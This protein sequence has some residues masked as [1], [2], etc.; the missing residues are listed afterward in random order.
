MAEDLPTITAEVTD[1][2][3]SAT[4]LMDNLNAIVTDNSDEIEVFMQAGLPQLVRFVKEA[5][6]LVAN[7]QRLTAKI[8]RDPARFL[9]GIQS[10]EFR[11]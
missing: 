11:R 8:E 6:L 1:T 4:T 10:P 2:L 7:L 9:L 3:G 5:N